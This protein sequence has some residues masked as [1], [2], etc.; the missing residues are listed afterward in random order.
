MSAKTQVARV[1][2]MILSALALAGADSRLRPV[3][4]DAQHL[5]GSWKAVVTA[6]DPPLL[7][8]LKV[9]L[10]FTRDG[11][12]VETRRLY[13]PESPFGPLLFTPGHGAWE[14]TADDQF[15]ATVVDFFQAAPNN[16]A[17]DGTVLGEE[18]VRYR[19]TLDPAGENLNGQLIGEIKDS[20]GN[21]VFTFSANVRA[22]RIH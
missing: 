17:A 11:G 13:N 16:P 8:P 22:T 21:V 3:K 10:T 19:V 2:L 15:A 5:E 9:L 6:T 4:A 14:R 7:P 1:S 20:E 12:V 18:E